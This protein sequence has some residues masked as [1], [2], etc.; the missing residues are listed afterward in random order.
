MRASRNHLRAFVR[1]LYIQKGETYQPQRL[2]P[3]EFEAIIA[4][5]MERGN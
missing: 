3:Q 1:V 2:S 5:E 4:G